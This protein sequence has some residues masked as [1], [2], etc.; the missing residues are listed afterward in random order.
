MIKRESKIKFPEIKLM[1]TLVKAEKP[2]I[3]PKEINLRICKIWKIYVPLRQIYKAL[4]LEFDEDFER[5]SNKI[6]YY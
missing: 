5:E 4:D 3:S 1:V 2:L 6:K